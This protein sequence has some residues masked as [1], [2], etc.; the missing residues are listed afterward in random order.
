ME[1][2]FKFLLAVITVGVILII[3]GMALGT[4][5][6]AITKKISSDISQRVSNSATAIAAANRSG[7]NQTGPLEIAVSDD[8]GPQDLGGKKPVKK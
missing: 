8:G 5:N 3:T 6:T 7:S 4:L 1:L 2:S